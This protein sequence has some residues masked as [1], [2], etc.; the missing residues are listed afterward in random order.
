[1]DNKDNKNSEF[2]LRVREAR[3]VR[4][5]RVYPPLAGL[6][7]SGGFIRLWRVYPPLAGLSA[8]GGF[9]RL[10]RVYPPLAGLSASGGPRA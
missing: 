8:F 1:M 5:W 6:S 10:W 3:L 4:L 2:R 7:A 9:I